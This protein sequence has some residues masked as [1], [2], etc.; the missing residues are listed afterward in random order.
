[1]F[2]ASD[3]KLRE[4]NRTQGDRV[5]QPQSGGRLFFI[6]DM[7]LNS[8]PAGS[9]TMLAEHAAERLIAASTSDEVAAGVNF[10]PEEVEGPHEAGEYDDA[11]EYAGGS[12][13]PSPIW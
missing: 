5:P 12:D 10:T 4:F 13:P 6:P 1:M 2:R 7:I 11:G 8:G 3:L 9:T